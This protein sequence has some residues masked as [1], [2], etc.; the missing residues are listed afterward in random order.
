MT[1]T[2]QPAARTAHAATLTNR[3]EAKLSGV[4]EVLAYDEQFISAVCDYG[5]VTIAG[6]GLKILGF[7]SKQ[8]VLHAAGKIAS[9]AYIDKREKSA[10]LFGRFMR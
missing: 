3:E 8:G 10:S 1:Q 6:S 5:E 2:E 4:R 9:L 7:D